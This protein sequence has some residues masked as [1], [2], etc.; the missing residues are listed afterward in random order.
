M[1]SSA[2]FK[3]MNALIAEAVALCEAAQERFNQIHDELVRAIEEGRRLTNQSFDEERKAR[4]ALF[5]ARVRLSTRQRKLRQ[6]T[7]HGE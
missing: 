4:M 7:Q 2:D 6:L 5:D 1:A 3:Q